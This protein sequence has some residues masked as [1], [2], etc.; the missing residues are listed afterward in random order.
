MDNKNLIL[1]IV[2][3][4]GILAGF[5]YFYI[6]P[7]QEHYR[8][9][10]EEQKR[11]Q[12]IK[13]DATPEA[14]PSRARADVVASSPRIKISTPELEGSIDLKGAALDDLALVRYRESIAP[15]APEITLLS[16]PG[17]APPHPA[18]FAEFSWLAGD[19]SLPMPNAQTTW[20]AAGK[21]LSPSAPVTLTWDNGQGL[22]FSRTIAVDDHY[23]FTVT[24]TVRNNRSAPVELYPFA[25]IGRQ[26]KPNTR[27]I[28]ILHEGP[29]GVLNGTLEEYKY[30]DLVAAGKKTDDSTGGWLGIT[31][32]YWLVALV[33]PQD[34]K[35]TA[36]F[37]YKSGADASADPAQGY[38]QTDF[39]GDAVTLAPGTVTTHVTRLFAGAKQLRLLDHYEEQLGIPH[40]DRAIDFG[41]FYFLTKP[42]LYLLDWLGRLFG[43]FGLAILAFTVMLKVVTLPLSVKSYRAMG[44]MKA[45][46]PEMKRL[47][48]RF[49]DDKAKQGA[50][51]MELYKRE[52]VNPASGCLPTLI[53]IPI[54]FALYK[55]LYVG[56]E[57]W[58]APFYGWI[59]D[60][61]QPDPTSVF[62]LFGAIPWTPP[63]ALHIGVWPILMGISMFLQQRLSPQ[64]PDKT[65]ARMFMVMPF[66]FTY[67][68]SQMPAGLVIY[69]TWSNL[70]SILQQW[71]IMRH[72]GAARR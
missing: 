17:S 43:N 8:Q 52:S 42:F 70:L 44:K 67:M 1:A 47:Q 61:S 58:Q 2:L 19:A 29:L 25:Y 11:T 69:W 24:D 46:Q 9:Q 64:P 15:D 22:D 57:M 53:Q 13:P 51:M 3:S 16:P 31:D 71:F 60:L 36:G 63:P 10:L 6:K 65:Q 68:L 41:W 50:A 37:T 38:F 66:I 30:K 14:A 18:Y 20:T 28:Y 62:T 5:Q 59:H 34:E 33:P 23:M 55:V 56:I 40:F 21:E 32:K 4:V 39:R 48:E 7:Q 45:L 12:P 49:A 54:F 72:A 35:L 27:D 26:G